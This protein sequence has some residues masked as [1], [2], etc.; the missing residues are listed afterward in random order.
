MTLID[1][2][3]LME[4]RKGVTSCFHKPAPKADASAD[5]RDM[6]DSLFYG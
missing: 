6:Q 3:T 5:F 2:L 1:H 4:L